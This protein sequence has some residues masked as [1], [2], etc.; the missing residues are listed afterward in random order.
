MEDNRVIVTCPKCGTKN[1]IP[2]DRLKDNPVCGKCRTPLSAQ[3]S[4]DHPV[5]ITDQTFQK[6]VL[7]YPG[8]VLV[9]C[10]APW[11]GPCRMVAPVLDQLAKEYASRIKFAKLN[12][13]EN[14]RIAAQFSIQS[15]P[16]LLFFKGG[17]LVN[18]Q[19]GALPKGEIERHLQSIL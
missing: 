9:D 14:Q 16:T 19:V 15:I 10:W 7:F 5:D 2:K 18:R 8:S 17:K 6:E 1:R 3:L 11:C 13:D 4:A 12:T